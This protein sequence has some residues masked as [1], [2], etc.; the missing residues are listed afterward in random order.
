MSDPRTIREVNI[1]TGGMEK[2][3]KLLQWV[4]GGI[5]ALLVALLGV[6]IAQYR[7]IGKVEVDV[8]AIK[9]TVEGIE[10]RL[11]LIETDLR[12]VRT[13]QGQILA[14][15]QTPPTPPAPPPTPPPR[16]QDLIAGGF[17]ITDAEASLIRD[18]LKAGPKKP[19][20]PSKIALWDRLPQSDTQPLPDDLAAKL[21]KIKGL[22]FTTDVNNA[23]ALVEPSQNVVIAII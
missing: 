9:A 16:L 14:K 6:G 12:A 23:I 15:I 5:C 21:P 2:R 11:G 4:G 17:Y 10:K 7:D 8:G 19:D 18:F 20:V 1:A 3:I 13:D 22:R